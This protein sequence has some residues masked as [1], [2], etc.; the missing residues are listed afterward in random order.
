MTARCMGGSVAMASS[1]TMRVS[2][3][4]SRSSGR[5]SH[6]AGGADQAP[7]VRPPSWN[8]AGSTEGSCSPPSASSAE[9]GTLRRSRTPLVLARL[10]RMRKI[11]VFRDERPSKR[12]IPLST[13]SQVSCTTSSACSFV[14]TYDNASRSREEWYRSTRAA[15]AVSSPWRRA[16]TTAASSLTSQTVGL[17]E[18]QPDLAHGREGGN[19]VPQPVQGDLAGDGNG[20]GVQ[21]VGH[22]GPDEG[23]ADEDAPVFVDH[24]PA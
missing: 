15:N 2:P 1:T 14:A 11:H 16:S 23:G 9:N 4:R 19:G 18:P 13:P 3:E 6:D 20:G 17:Q 10:T 5:P 12:S 7:A 8:R 24:E 22:A 21:E